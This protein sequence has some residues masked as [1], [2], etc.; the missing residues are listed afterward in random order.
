LAYDKPAVLVV[1]ALRVELQRFSQ[2]DAVDILE[3]GVGPVE[4]AIATAAALARKPYEAVINVGIGGAFRPRASVGEAVLVVS[5]ALADLGLEGG[6]PLVLPGGTIL[7]ERQDAD[8]GLLRDVASLGLKTARGVTVSSVTT[9]AATAQRLQSR[10]DA[11]IESM[12][13]FSVLRAAAAA[14]V[15]ALQLR[16]VSNY[17]GPRADG[18]WDFVAGS[19]AASIALGSVLERLAR[20]SRI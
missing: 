7:V 2:S 20:G 3:T 5:D 4:A 11:D 1:C 17:V 19:Q 8:A 13:G 12:E 14:R 16:G 6:A 15:P 9:T 18:E 10:Y